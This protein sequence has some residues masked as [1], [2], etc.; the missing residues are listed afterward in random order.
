MCINHAYEWQH[1]IDKRK[2]NPL[3]GILC[4]NR[5]KRSGD[6]LCY[7]NFCFSL[8]NIVE[9]KNSWMVI[10][11]RSQIFFSVDTVTLLFLPL[12]MLLRV[13]CV[14]P[15]MVAN[16]LIEMQRSLH[17]SNIRFWTAC[18]IVMYYPPWYRYNNIVYVFLSTNYLNWVDFLRRNM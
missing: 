18:L 16:R 6:F 14:M 12:I 1:E 3:S 5:G 9:L 10:S 2:E 8:S 17:R 11:R 4:K 15:Q 7:F 13:D